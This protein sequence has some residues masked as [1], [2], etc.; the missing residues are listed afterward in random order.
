MNI[1]IMTQKI[2]FNRNSI[3][4]RRIPNP[5]L[6][7]RTPR[8]TIN[9]IP[10]IHIKHRSVFA[11]RLTPFA[12][13]NIRNKREK[14]IALFGPLFSGAGN[15]SPDPVR[16]GPGRCLPLRWAGIALL[17][18]RAQTNPPR[19]DPFL[20]KP[21]RVVTSVSENRQFSGLGGASGGESGRTDGPP[22]GIQSAGSP[23]CLHTFSTTRSMESRW[24][25]GRE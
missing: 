3:R 22:A 16:Q 9:K 6:R 5:N 24:A 12:K 19:L 4:A 15:S 20:D 10:T 1:R 18:K 17:R 8:T 23:S 21:G 14:A 25:G 7:S 2:L 11:F 13:A